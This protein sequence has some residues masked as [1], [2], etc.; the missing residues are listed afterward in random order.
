MLLAFCF[1]IMCV[2]AY[3]FRQSIFS[4]IGSLLYS[5]MKKSIESCAGKILVET[6]RPADV[7]EDEE[8][9]K[10]VQYPL[11]QQAGCPGFMI[12]VKMVG[13]NFDLNSKENVQYCTPDVAQDVYPSNDLA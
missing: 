5:M 12:N 11:V 2:L 8:T 10:T 1:A 13:Q 3:V 6:A 7:V 9:R 4:C